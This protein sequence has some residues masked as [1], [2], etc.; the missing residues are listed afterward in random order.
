MRPLI[1]QFSN[2]MGLGGDVDNLNLDEILDSRL[3]IVKEITQ[4]FKNPAQTTFICVCIPEFLS[5]YETERL[6]QVS[7]GAFSLFVFICNNNYERATVP[8]RF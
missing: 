2:L 7:G 8:Q 4:Q 3:P 6:V 1:S 5:M